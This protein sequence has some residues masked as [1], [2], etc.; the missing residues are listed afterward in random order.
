MRASTGG[1]AEVEWTGQ[2]LL[3]VGWESE[4][5]DEGEHQGEGG[6]YEVADGDDAEGGS[7]DGRLHA[8]RKASGMHR[9]GKRGAVFLAGKAGV[10]ARARA[11]ARAKAGARAGAGE[12]RGRSV[13]VRMLGDKKMVRNTQF[14]G[15][16][17]RGGVGNGFGVVTTHQTADERRYEHGLVAVGDDSDG[18]GGGDGEGTRH[19]PSAPRGVRW[20]GERN[21][22]MRAQYK[23]GERALQRRMVTVVKGQ[24]FT[25]TQGA[26][27]EGAVGGGASAAD[28]G[29]D[30]GSEAVV[31]QQ[32]SSVYERVGAQTVWADWTCLLGF[33]VMGI[34][35]HP[36][37]SGP[38]GV[39]SVAGHVISCHL[40][41]CGGFLVTGDR[42]GLLK[43]F[44][45]PSVVEHA[46]FR[47]YAGHASRVQ[48]VEFADRD[49]YVLS[50]GGRDGATLQW[51]VR[52]LGKKHQG[53]GKGDKNTGRGAG[54][55]YRL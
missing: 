23:E 33:P 2:D 12:A 20:E 38:V 36:G 44:H 3:P 29:T 24:D 45:F 11:K 14:M 47:S 32:L 1:D 34:W 48:A 37:A 49:R 8:V 25:R 15:T 6:G 17:S 27:E 26:Y 46:P 55:G 52:R 9:R 50:S 4:Y 30:E 21:K 40:S 53:H 54:P 39:T 42:D 18:G 51:R 43:I 16:D 35:P 28:D 41:S 31:V 22:A 5:G 10:K 7:E 19:I 13:K